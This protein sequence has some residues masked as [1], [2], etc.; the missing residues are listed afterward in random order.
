MPAAFVLLFYLCAPPAE[1]HVIMACRA[2]EIVAPTCAQAIGIAE[3][4][5]V[6]GHMMFTAACVAAT[7]VPAPPA[8][9]RPRR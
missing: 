2:R 8:A 1:G 6:P 3:A 4:S 7:G 5:I 9:Q